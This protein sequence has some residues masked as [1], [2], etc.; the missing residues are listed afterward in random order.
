MTPFSSLLKHKRAKF[1]QTKWSLFWQ[2]TWKMM[3]LPA[4][5]SAILV[6]VFPKIIFREVISGSKLNAQRSGKFSD[7]L[8]H[9]GSQNSKSSTRGKGRIRGSPA[10]HFRHLEG[11]KRVKLLSFFAVWRPF[12]GCGFVQKMGLFYKFWAF[13]RGKKPGGMRKI[14]QKGGCLRWDMSHFS[15][16]NFDFRVLSEWKRLQFHD[17]EASNRGV[18]GMAYELLSHN[19]T[20]G[21]FV[22]NFDTK[23]VK[24]GFKNWLKNPPFF[25][26]SGHSAWTLRSPP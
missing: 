9:F 26:T 12:G 5:P 15:S 22:Y 8:P 2:K 19:P 6:L 11:R 3:S 4:G 18:H 20:S 13:P 1:F 24:L 25:P 16:E 10:R 14:R 7:F 21:Y 17:Q 23:S